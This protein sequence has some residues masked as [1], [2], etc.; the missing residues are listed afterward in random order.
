MIDVRECRRLTVH[1]IRYETPYDIP[2]QG[3]GKGKPLEQLL[4]VHRV[5]VRPIIGIGR[6]F[7]GEVRRRRRRRYAG[8]FAQ[9]TNM[10]NA[11]YVTVTTK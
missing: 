3:G 4:V 1:V 5:L 6:F 7:V 10:I 11:G 2:D 8:G 9:L